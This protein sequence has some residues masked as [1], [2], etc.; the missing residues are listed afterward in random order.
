MQ[1]QFRTLERLT[2]AI[3]ITGFLGLVGVVVLTVIDVGLR[4]GGGQ[5][6]PGFDDYGQI[7]FPIIIASC[8]PVGLLHNRNIAIT[9]LGMGLGVRATRVLTLFAAVLTLVFFVAVAWRFVIMTID[10]GRT[11]A[12]SPTV[13]MPVTPTWWLAT[14]LLWLTVPIQT[15]VVWVRV[16]ELWQGRDLLPAP[17]FEKPE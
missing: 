2:V 10:L 13:L 7:L 11:G 6:L 5:R 14:G 3:A 12:V 16:Q 9:F 17:Q 8:F 4:Y 1:Q 15:W